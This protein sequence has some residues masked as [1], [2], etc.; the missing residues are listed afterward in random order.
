MLSSEKHKDDEMYVI[1][2]SMYSSA[3]PR[4]KYAKTSSEITIVGIIGS[5]EDT[6]S[7]SG[8]IV[9]LSSLQP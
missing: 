2:P 8:A 9:Y 7:H 6:S 3:P 5:N 4:F 1:N